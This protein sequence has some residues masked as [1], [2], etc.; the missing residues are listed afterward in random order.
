[1][2]SLIILPLPTGILA[3]ES[4]NDQEAVIP[5]KLMMKAFLLQEL[6]LL[7]PQSLGF[8]QWETLIPNGS[9]GVMV[10]KT[11]ATSV[12][13][14]HLLYLW[15]HGTIYCS[16]ILSMYCTLKED[17]PPFFFLMVL[18]SNVPHCFS[19]RVSLSRIRLSASQR[20]VCDQYPMVVYSHQHLFCTQV[21]YLI[22]CNI[23]HDPMFVAQILWGLSDSTAGWSLENKK[24][25]IC[26]YFNQGEFLPFL[27][28]MESS[29]TT[30]YQEVSW[31]PPG[32]GFYWALCIHLFNSRLDIWQHSS[33]WWG[34]TALLGCSSYY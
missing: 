29:V 31:S 5:Q 32:T 11:T 6:G 1:M 28:W 34:T 4:W 3:Q 14:I 26:V 15:G 9:L 25:G 8:Q 12:S 2:I 10:R 30:C 7:S 23:M 17:S 22:F 24:G 21:C 16:Y 18:S 27:E 13:C 20:M 19:K 33:C